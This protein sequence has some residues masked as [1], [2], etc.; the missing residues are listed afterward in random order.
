MQESANRASAAASST[1][2]PEVQ[3]SNGSNCSGYAASTHDMRV[4]CVPPDSFPTSVG[5]LDAVP[6]ASQPRSCK[7]PLQCSLLHE[8]GT[9]EICNQQSLA[10]TWML[11][12]ELGSRHPSAPIAW[13][14]GSLLCEAPNPHPAQCW[15]VS[16]HNA[17]SIARIKLVTSFSRSFSRKSIKIGALRFNREL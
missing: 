8:M 6:L 17:Q 9:L 12:A 2:R 13:R 14:S 3:S 16:H 1:V 4:S 11:N 10:Q 15:Q 5:L 7:R